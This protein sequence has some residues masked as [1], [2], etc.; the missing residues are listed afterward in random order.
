MSN[1]ADGL[2]FQPRIGE[3]ESSIAG[4]APLAGGPSQFLAPNI[5]DTSIGAV[6]L[7]QAP[8]WVYDF[9]P[10]T[11]SSRATFNG[12]VVAASIS[13]PAAGVSSFN[14]R[15][16]AVVLTAA[17]VTGAGGLANPSPTLTGVPNAP[18]AAPGTNSTQ[19]ATC[20]FVTAAV[21]ADAGVSTFNGRAGAITL[22]AGD[23]TGAGGAPAVSPALTG[24]PTA[25]TAAQGDTSS[26][27]ATDAFVANA[28]AAGTV[29]TFNG[30]RGAV[31]LTLSDVQSV[32]GAPIASPTFTGSPA[33]PTAAPGT[34]TTQAAST[35]FVTNAISG[36]TA[37][38]ASFN[39][40]TGA[41]VLSTADVIAAGGAPI[42]SPTF[43]GTPAAPTPT[44]GDNSTKIATTAYVETAIGSLPAGVSTFNGRA[45]TVTLQL[46]DVTSVGG[47][48]LASP[49]FTGSPLSTTAAPGDNS[50]RIATTAFVDAALP[51]ASAA[52]P[53][54][55]GV[56]SVGVDPG[57]SHGDH[58]HPV[59]TSRYAASNPS[60]FQTAAQV[61]ASLANYF[62]ITGG[63]ISGGVT[64]NG[65]L[66][67][68][69][70]T[71]NLTTSAGGSNPII[72][73]MN[74]ANT[75]IA[76]W[77]ASTSTGNI[78]FTA[79]IVGGSIQF[80]GD[81]QIAAAS[82]HNLLLTTGV[83]FQTGGGPWSSLSD[84]RVKNLHEDFEAGLAELSQL[85]PV[86]YSYKGNDSLDPDAPSLHAEAAAEGTRFVG[87]IAQEVEAIFPAMVGVR[88]GYI[89]G[90]PVDDLRTLNTGPITF[91]LINA[92]KELSAR[93]AYLESR[94]T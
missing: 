8:A 87:L 32:G 84:V 45:G 55:N 38:V 24:V 86:V 90:E 36:A 56:G 28:I 9:D 94:G 80:T 59:D 33:V 44:A 47:A 51:A 66:A 20:Q 63:A 13:T 58:V 3:P 15:T 91:A 23:V 27:I 43:T 82:G 76:A 42:V 31:N 50:T 49:T 53:L 22:T 89:D 92:V 41:V 29:L 7:Q 52:T 25:P 83:G 75:Q 88:S 35:A 30:R 57:W 67:A 18:T 14:T 79:P 72:Q 77:S 78:A 6:A 16:G 71:F 69:V 11:G 4:A 74:A 2:N 12:E 19:L 10:G 5:P 85:R 62:P 48:P 70:G 39:T 81:L 93:V 34:A 26:Q 21:N 68:N 40:R 65:T 64:I 1:M 37:G 54:M 17:D 46:A 61:T 60:G 73:L